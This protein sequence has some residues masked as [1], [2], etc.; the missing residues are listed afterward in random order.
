MWDYEMSL[1]EINSIEC[2]EKGNVVSWRT[3]KNVGVD[4]FEVLPKRKFPCKGNENH[5]RPCSYFGNSP[6][7]I[8]FVSALVFCFCGGFVSC[9]MSCISL[10]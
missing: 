5:Y 6:T 9:L 2:S 8:I 1:D 3:L 4:D 7:L 10:G